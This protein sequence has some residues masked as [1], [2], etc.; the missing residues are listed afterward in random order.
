M[1][2]LEEEAETYSTLTVFYN[3]ETKEIP[4]EKEIMRDEYISEIAFKAGAKSKYVQAE[5]IKAQIDVLEDVR[6]SDTI[7]WVD[8]KIKELEQQLKQLEGD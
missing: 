3:A 8:S 6:N 5:K 7:F 2:S 4:T 1:I